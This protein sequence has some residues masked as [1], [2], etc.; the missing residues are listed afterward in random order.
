MKTL[1]SQLENLTEREL[2]W[3]RAFLEDD[4]QALEIPRI[5][6]LD[7]SEL[8]NRVSKIL[9]MENRD[10]YTE[11]FINYYFN[12]FYVKD[13]DVGWA[14]H[15]FSASVWLYY[16][17]GYE[18]KYS[19]KS[20]KEIINYLEFLINT[21]SFQYQEG[22]LVHFSYD[23]A[24][25]NFN[26]R[27]RENLDSDNKVSESKIKK[28]PS[29]LNDMSHA[30][31]DKIDRFKQFQKEFEGALKNVKKQMRWLKKEDQSQINWCYN[32]MQER[33]EDFQQKF[34]RDF[35]LF[36]F[37]YLNK[38]TEDNLTTKNNKELGGLPNYLIEFVELYYLDDKQTDEKY[39]LIIANLWILYHN[40]NQNKYQY[41]EAKYLSKFIKL[42]NNA[43]RA[44]KKDDKDKKKVEIKLFSKNAKKLENCYKEL[45]LPKV[46]N[47]NHF[48]N[49][50]IEKLDNELIKA[51]IEL[52]RHKDK[53]EIEARIKI[54]ASVKNFKVRA[55]DNTSD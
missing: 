6:N 40:L 2:R 29:L 44:K 55:S 41:I 37:F 4:Y 35:R 27:L 22:I 5:V 20:K 10:P 32:Y 34:N 16:F 47:Y 11:R 51:I 28:L 8:I 1:L 12:E 48:V 46:R 17:L 42:M 25:L 39:E 3:F 43:W 45:E 30:F 31:D 7:K 26:R 38:S 21:E 52:D 18:K 19:P 50:L 9:K 23:L 33:F 14:F 49:F 54:P 24:Q 36:Q 15:N 53:E 13:T